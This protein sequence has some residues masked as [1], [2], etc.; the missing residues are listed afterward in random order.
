MQERQLKLKTSGAAALTKGVKQQPS[1]LESEKD[2]EEDEEYYDSMD[3]GDEFNDD[4][5]QS[6]KKEKLKG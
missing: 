6:Y 5:E 1:K 3:Y 2:E 4:E